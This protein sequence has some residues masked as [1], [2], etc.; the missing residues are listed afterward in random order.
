[1]ET[2]KMR[3]RNRLVPCILSGLLLCG[4][5]WA[6]AQTRLLVGMATGSDDLRGGNRAFITLVLTD[7]T[8]LPFQLLSTG[9][10]ANSSSIR[11]VT[12][13]DTVA[14]NRIKTIRIVHD[15]NPRSGHPFDSQDNWDL[16]ALGVSLANASF[17]GVRELYSSARDSKRA[18]FVQRFTGS[19]RQLDIVIR[20]VGCQPDFTILGMTG[21]PSGIDL[22]IRNIG[23]C[24]GRPTRITCT[25]FGRVLTHSFPSSF[26]LGSGAALTQRVGFLPAGTVTCFIDGTDLG[27][28]PEVVTANNGFMR[29]F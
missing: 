24:A 23:A 13:P 8:V 15:G 29:T 5:T 18:V 3:T 22:R 19:A 20:A 9:E 11:R 28:R 16:R 27:V 4:S 6:A 14:A 26:V 2:R 25:A 10:P 17:V 12:F 1:M 7:D 21:S